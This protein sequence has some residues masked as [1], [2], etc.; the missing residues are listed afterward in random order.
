MLLCFLR[1]EIGGSTIIAFCLSYLYEYTDCR[2]AM[3]M[4]YRMVSRVMTVRELRSCV[5]A[6]ALLGTI[7]YQ[8]LEE[9]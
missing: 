7:S 9:V 6:G 4:Q 2:G 5:Q 1:E 3:M 8:V